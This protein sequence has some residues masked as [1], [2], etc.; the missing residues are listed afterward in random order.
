MIEILHV[1]GGDGDCDPTFYSKGWHDPLEWHAALISHMEDVGEVIPD[2]LRDPGG[3]V[4]GRSRCAPDGHGDYT[5]ILMPWAR[6][7]SQGAYDVISH[8]YFR[9]FVDHEWSTLSRRMNFYSPDLE[10]CLR[11][12]EWETKDELLHKRREQWRCKCKN[13]PREECFG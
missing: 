6:F 5:W 7:G 3:V 13:R 1:G 10:Q 4:W 12:G 2:A 8:E 9:Y 11:C